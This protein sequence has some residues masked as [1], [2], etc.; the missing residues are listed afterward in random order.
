[1]RLCRDSSGH[2]NPTAVEAALCRSFAA[3]DFEILAD[4]ARTGARSGSTAC[5]VLQLG[6]DLYCAHAGVPLLQFTFVV[7]A[8][9]VV[10]FATQIVLQ[11][12]KECFAG[13][14]GPGNS[15]HAIPS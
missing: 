7:W 15:N 8:M 4:A 2:L 11:I 1:M 14:T 10:F 13:Y 6:G 5:V 12:T 9:W 3:M